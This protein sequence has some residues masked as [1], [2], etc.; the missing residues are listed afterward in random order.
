MQTEREQYKK[1]LSWWD[2]VQSI[3]FVMFVFKVKNEKEKEVND[4][5]KK[6]CDTVTLTPNSISLGENTQKEVRKCIIL[7]FLT[8]GL[9]FLKL[10]FK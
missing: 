4:N 9:T 5:N 7:H 1:K 8:I 6:N 10:G 2:L 3:M